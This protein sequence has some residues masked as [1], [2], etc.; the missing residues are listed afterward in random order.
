MDG[1]S[2]TRRRGVARLPWRG[3]AW[4]AV[5]CRGVACRGV[6]CR[7]VACR[8]VPCRGVPWRGVI[9]P[10]RSISR[11]P[12]RVCRPL[13]STDK[14]RPSAPNQASTLGR[15]VTRASAPE[16]N[17]SDA[18][19]HLCTGGL[20]GQALLE[21][22]RHLSERSRPVA[23]RAAELASFESTARDRRRYAGSIGGFQS[24]AASSNPANSKAGV[25]MQP[26]SVQAPSARAICHAPA[27]TTAWTA[28]PPAISPP[29]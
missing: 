6:A 27:G 20:I 10:R 14:T 13:A 9:H 22:R 8:G 7:G 15:P 25:T 29:R 11:V 26:T 16:R 21:L 17:V 1:I 24:A 19:R 4:R 12:T 28:E 3:V 5:A 18:G 23:I 2:A